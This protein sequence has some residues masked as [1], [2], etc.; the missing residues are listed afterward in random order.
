MITFSPMFLC[1]HSLRITASE[2]VQFD[3]TRV[4]DNIS[5]ISTIAT[6]TLMVF[7]FN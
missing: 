1:L 4:V 2:H 6:V 5:V 3:V 7:I